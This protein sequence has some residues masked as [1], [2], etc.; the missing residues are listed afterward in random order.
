MSARHNWAGQRLTLDTP[1]LTTGPGQHL[2][3]RPGSQA[4]PAGQP[5]SQHS[6]SASRRPRSPPAPRCG[7]PARLGNSLLGRECLRPSSGFLHCPMSWSSWETQDGLSVSF[8]SPSGLHPLT[9][10]HTPGNRC[11]GGAGLGTG[12]GWSILAG[13][14]ECGPPGRGRLGRRRGPSEF[15]QVAETVFDCKLSTIRCC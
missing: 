7:T 1:I 15:S 3:G 5:H 6:G 14:T 11:P 10:H 9:H 8:L 12:T 2:R 13:G 4:L